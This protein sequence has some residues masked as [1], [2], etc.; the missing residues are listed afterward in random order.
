MITPPLTSSPLANELTASEIRWTA[1]IRLEAIPGQELSAYGWCKIIFD[2]PA[3]ARNKNVK[4]LLGKLEFERRD[5][6]RGAAA[7]ELWRYGPAAQASVARRA[8]SAHQ[9]V[10]QQQANLPA[11]T[12]QKAKTR[13]K[14]PAAQRSLPKLVDFW[15]QSSLGTTTS[16]ETFKK[17]TSDYKNILAAAEVLGMLE[18]HKQPGLGEQARLTALGIR[19]ASEDKAVAEAAC[20]ETLAAYAP[21]GRLMKKM[22]AGATKEAASKDLMLAYKWSPATTKNVMH[23]FGKLIERLNIPATFSGRGSKDGVERHAKGLARK[24]EQERSQAL[25]DGLSIDAQEEELAARLEASRLLFA[26][27]AASGGGFFSICAARLHRDFYG[28]SASGAMAEESIAKSFREEFE[29]C[30]GAMEALRP[31]VDGRRLAK[32]VFDDL[33]KTGWLAASTDYEARQITFRPAPLAKKVMAALA[34]DEMAGSSMSSGSFR[35]CLRALEDFKESG[36]A[37]HLI[38]AMRSARD[39]NEDLA[40]EADQWRSARGLLISHYDDDKAFSTMSSRLSERLSRARRQ[41]G[42]HGVEANWRGVREWLALAR[43]RFSPDDPRLADLAEELS[44]ACGSSS[45]WGG[46]GSLALNWAIEEIEGLVTSA[47]TV[48]GPELAEAMGAF[49][50]I[51]EQ[52]V[53]SRAAKGAQ[54]RLAER[55]KNLICAESVSEAE[56]AAEDLLE[57]WVIGRAQALRLD[58]IELPGARA[59]KER[60]APEPI[61][62]MDPWLS[63]ESLAT[64]LAAQAADM[65]LDEMSELLAEK[66]KAAPFYL[67]EL[68][69]DGWDW[70]SVRVAMSAWQLSME[71]SSLF[72]CSKSRG[73]ASLGG[74]EQ[75]DF[76]VEWTG[77]LDGDDDFFLETQEALHATPQEPTTSER[78]RANEIALQGEAT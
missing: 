71:D 44:Y 39:V 54:E 41:M 7:T 21:Y 65:S 36:E 51:S 16:I 29:R 25:A 45:F 63:F 40:T 47:K 77:D 26:P 72:S 18:R 22:G 34:K 58:G 53:A 57:G 33:C 13:T 6:F 20:S 56:A 3:G 75:E 48:R 67:S 17:L 15:K 19:L 59:L 42:I 28:P 35:N 73:V 61:Q 49:A 24:K 1:L 70:T 66:A 31:G 46:D 30:R 76:L 32:E 9:P 14:F 50:K 10:G 23:G 74:V 60:S 78:A 69:R 12:P 52:L 62:E 8:G 4:M 68:G 38:D 2:S 64:A 27:L 55:V 43:G 5:V 11:K 37:H